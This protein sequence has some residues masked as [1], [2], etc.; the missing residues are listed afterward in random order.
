MIALALAAGGIAPA[1]ALAQSID[2]N[3]AKAAFDAGAN[4]PDK[5]DERAKIVGCAAFWSQW[6]AAV[7]EQRV[8]ADA[9]RLV[10]PLLVAPD[11]NVMAFGWLLV[12]IE[13]VGNEDPAA[14]EAE[15]EAAMAE[16]EP[17]AKGKVDAAL[18]G[19]G[20]ALAG[21]MSLLGICHALPE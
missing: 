6:N 3:A 15:V 12:S 18:A 1:P 21:V 5:P 4:G 10:S 16:V 14:V 7:L 9:G 11:S 13:P 20:A 17:F 19:D 8:P 2:W